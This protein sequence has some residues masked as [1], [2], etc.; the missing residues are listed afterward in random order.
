[1]PQIALGYDQIRKA[2]F[3]LPVEKR[4]D[5]LKEIKE[6]DLDSA[7]NKAYRKVSRKIRA[8]GYSADDVDL[9][10]SDARRKGS[11]GKTPR[12]S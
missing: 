3:K 2:V 1:M 4:L 7:F 11:I 8:S 5:L 12:R 10:I 9:L 6:R